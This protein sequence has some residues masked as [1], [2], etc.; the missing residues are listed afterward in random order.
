MFSISRK[1]K[2]FFVKHLSLMIKGGTSISEALETLRDETESKTLKK[3]LD[4]V[5]KKVL[6]GESLARSLRC[7]PRIFDE[8][9]C[10]VVEIGEK[11]G[12]LEENLKYLAFQLRSNYEMREKVRGASIYPFFII[13]MAI[14]IASVVTFFILPKITSLF[15]LLE[16]ELPLATKVLINSAV[17]LKIYWFYILV[18]IILFILLIKLL[19]TLPF[20]R[21]FFDKIT[22]SL[23]IFG[24]LFKNL[25]LARFSRT[26]YTLSKSGVPLLE[27]FEICADTIPN[28]VYRRN[29]IQVRSRVERGEKISQGLK[30]FP[31]IFPLFFS[32]MI[33]VGERSGT[34]EESLLS[35]A[36]HHETEVDL[37]LKRLSTVIEPILLILVGIFVAFVALAIITPIYQ[38]VGQV[39][40]HQ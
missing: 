5:L 33:I 38:F 35:L 31:K 13:L 19:R 34:L 23:P 17:F 8:F 9:F 24:L 10:S 20:I 7:Y 26:F 32:R 14:T 40:I 30:D 39:R 3:A 11:A 1:E 37:T 18:G 2:M 21:Y 12:S 25:N 15:K 4:D 36:E 22:L 16:I 28:E 6:E 27:T 29:L